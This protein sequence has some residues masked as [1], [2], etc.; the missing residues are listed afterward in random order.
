MLE[1]AASS[2]AFRIIALAIVFALVTGAILI[3][4]NGIEARRRASRQIARL[5]AA[6]SVDS[7]V[8]LLRDQRKD[9]WVKIAD[10]IEKSGI[11]LTDKN[12]LK[13][14]QQMRMAGYRSKAAVRTFT[15]ARIMLIF[16]IPGIYLLLSFFNSDPPSVFKLYLVSS[17]LAAAGLYL[18]NLYVRA[19]ADRR[20]E[21]IINGFPDA[22]DLILVCVEAGLGLEAALD[23]VGREM[24][25]SHTLIAELLVETTLLMRAG[26]SR[27]LALRQLADNSGVQEIRSFSTLLIQSDKLGT[28]I[29]DTLRIY[30]GEMREARRLRAEEKAHRIPVLVSIPLVACMLPVMVGVLALPAIIGFVRE[31]GPALAG[32]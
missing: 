18:P 21:R 27:E 2:T 3:V 20:K 28:S 1:I 4:V 6:A 14:E 23:K 25:R 9:R 32:G 17:I 7:Q 24:S 16:T 13:L 30:A 31:L 8:D 26:A 12:N 15:I 22:L 5:D 29:A 11:S 10:T 19:K